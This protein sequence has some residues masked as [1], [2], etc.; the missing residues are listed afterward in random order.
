[1]ISKLSLPMPVSQFFPKRHWQ[2]WILLVRYFVE[3]LSIWVFIIRLGYWFWGKNIPY[4]WIAPSH[5]LLVVYA[6]N[7]TWAGDVNP[8][9]LV[10]IVSYRFLHYQLNI[11]L[12]FPLL[13][14]RSESPSSSLTFK[15]EG[16][17]PCF[18]ESKKSVKEFMGMLKL[19]LTKISKIL[20][21]LYT[22]FFIKFVQ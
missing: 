8:D 19:P 6:I 14:C 15:R 17:T 16:V 3:Y 12:S 7:M 1:M 21:R 13:F 5:S 10:K 20:E 18:L 22:I 11:F 4:R 2:F 9:Q